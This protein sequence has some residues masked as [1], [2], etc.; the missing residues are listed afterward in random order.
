M[1]VIEYRGAG[2]TE[3]LGLAE[4]P[5]PMPGPGEVLVRVVAAGLNRPDVQQRRGLYPPPPG[6]SD[7][8]GLDLSGIVERAAPGTS[9]PCVGDAVCAI[10]TGAAHAEYCAVPAEQCLPIP[11][12]LS[13]V[14]AASLPEVFFTA[15]NNVIW[16]GRLGE[17]ETLL[18][19]GGTSGVGLAVIQIAKRLRAARV[20]ATA[21]TP[22]KRRA[23]LDTGADAAIDYRDPNWP[24]LVRNAAPEAG[25]DVILDAQAGDYTRP[26]M[27]LL[28]PDGRLVLIASHRGTEAVVDLRAV[29]RRRLTLTGSTLRP[30][31][32]AYKGRLARELREQV[33]PLLEN[34]QINTRIFAAF[35]M[36]RAA[37]AHALLDANEQI[38]KVVLV[39]DTA[40]ADSQPSGETAA[41]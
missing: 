17:G 36:E 18:V 35:P 30:R 16:L 22:E 10:V 25:V 33:W 7:I 19:Q 21:G 4:R 9:W 2:G 20:I 1:K 12:G 15:W 38:G 29:V 27:D 6:A 14:Q 32:P 28:A 26:Q 3:V 37:E 8:P 40:L 24:A 13:F 11:R 41:G 23:C 34:G 31:P 39:M 5:L